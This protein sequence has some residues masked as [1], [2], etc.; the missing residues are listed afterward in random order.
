[1]TRIATSLLREANTFDE[2]LEAMG[3]STP[4]FQKILKFKNFACGILGEAR[5]RKREI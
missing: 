1:M 5:G 4:N 2:Q 3:S